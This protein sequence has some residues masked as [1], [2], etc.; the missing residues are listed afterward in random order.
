MIDKAYNKYYAVCDQCG[1][2]HGPYHYWQDAKDYMDDND[3]STSYDKS[4]G[5]YIHKCEVCR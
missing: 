2:T 3:W 4:S 5:E 1:E